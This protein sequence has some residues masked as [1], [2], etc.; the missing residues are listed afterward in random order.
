MEIVHSNTM[1]MPFYIALAQGGNVIYNWV[2]N[3]TMK[4][5]LKVQAE[6]KF[7]KKSPMMFNKRSL[8]THTHTHTHTHTKL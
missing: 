1:K 2:Q 4:F 6:L 7:W 5:E 8:S 3:N